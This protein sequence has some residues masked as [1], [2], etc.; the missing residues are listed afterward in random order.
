MG[1]LSVWAL[2]CM[3]RVEFAHTELDLDLLIT[4]S[5]T[6]L[7]PSPITITAIVLDDLLID[8]LSS[9]NPRMHNFRSVL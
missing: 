1:L 3:R 4:H 9:V 7:T 5:Y 6:S 2:S 8:R